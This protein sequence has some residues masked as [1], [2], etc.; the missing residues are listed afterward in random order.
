LTHDGN[1][2]SF[3]RNGSL[4]LVNLRNN[5]FP[6][7]T[8]GFRADWTRD[9]LAERMA[10]FD[11]FWRIY[12]L[13]FYDS[14][15]HGRNWAEIRERYRPLLSSVGHRNEMATVLNMMVGELEASHAEVGSAPGNPRSQSTAHLGFEFDY[16]HSGIGVKIGKVPARSPGSFAR[17]RL[18]SGEFIVAINGQDVRLDQNLFRLLNDQ[19]GREVTLLVNSTPS[20]I[21]ARTVKYRALDFGAWVDLNYRNQI[22]ARRAFVDQRSGGRL[23]YLHIAGMGGGNLRDFNLEA[24][25]EI[26]GKEGAIIDVRENGGGNIADTLLDIL[27]RS[28]QMRYLPRDRRETMGPGTSW[29]KPTIVMHAESSLSN[30]E[31][32]PAAMKARGLATLVGM[33]TPGYVIYTYGGSL[34]DGTSIRQPSTGVFRLDGTPT[35]NLG[36]Q[37]DI[38][39]D[40]P[41]ED[42]L[43][44]KDP[45]LERAVQEGLR[46]LGR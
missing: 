37:P 24:W 31:M 10:A 36:Q 2:F 38:R 44:G 5:Q 23:A 29:G 42:W 27:E 32:F 33:P 39:V 34:V 18:N 3:L 11:Q 14:N 41:Y 25:E 16:S 43:A 8:V 13:T 9:V 26:Q 40:W 46:K 45:Q 1:Q 7:T 17:T 28:P 15:F 4:N 19:A 22:S 35:E 6:V 30:A 21:G 12:N 20:K